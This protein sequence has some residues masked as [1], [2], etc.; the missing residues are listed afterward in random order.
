MWKRRG[1]GKRRDAGGMCA[2]QLWQEQWLSF[3]VKRKSEIIEIVLPLLALQ[4]CF[5]TFENSQQ[6]A[7]K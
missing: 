3:P 5:L 2:S 1:L 6:E 7:G 4:L